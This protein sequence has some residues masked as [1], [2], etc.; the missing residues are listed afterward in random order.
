MQATSNRLVLSPSDLNDYVECPH[1]TTLALEVARG[2]RP[3]PWAPEDQ[4]DLLRRK[5][6]EHEAS[7]LAEL[8]KRGRQVVNV[9]TADPWDFATSARDTGE[10][11]RA[12]AE[13]IYQATFVQGDW[14]GRADFLERVDQPTTLG[15]WGYEALDAKLARAEKPTYVLQLCFYTEA[16]ASIQQTTPTAMHVL[17]GIGERV[18]LR[19]ADFAAYYRR[20]R[21]GF[22]A[23]IKRGETTEP[24]PVDHCALCEFRQVCDERW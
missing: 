6:E 13:I 5:G 12:G 2:T 20:V 14:R 9:I 10:A 17:L 7:Y 21:A 23:A 1:L 18:T 24:Y 16:I 4:A 15:T 22:L 11:M 8:R 19:H 3:R